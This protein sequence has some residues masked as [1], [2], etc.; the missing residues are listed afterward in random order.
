MRFVRSPRRSYAVKLAFVTAVTL[1][2]AACGITG[3]MILCIAGTTATADAA[4][5]IF[6]AWVFD[7]ADG[8]LAHHWH[9]QT[10]AGAILDSACDAISFGMLPALLV[11]RGAQPAFGTAAI[12]IGIFF[13]VCAIVRLARFTAKALAGTSSASRVWFAGLPSPVAAMTI[14]AVTFCTAQPAVLLAAATVAGVLMVSPL[15][16]ADLP[17]AYMRR[18]VPLW[19]VL[20]PLFAS[21]LFG[22]RPVLAA[23]CLAYLASG[24]LAAARAGLRTV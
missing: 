16:Y 3:I 7:L 4:G 21:A 11:A 14:G 15:P 2:N 19:T 23:V 1:A 9:V 5:L 20:L 17:R 13:G 12:V 18:R 24:A 10:N 8:P 22:W 6:A